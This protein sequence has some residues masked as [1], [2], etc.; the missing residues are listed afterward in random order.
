MLFLR[1]TS[2]NPDTLNYS[3]RG[4][5]HHSRRTRTKKPQRLQCGWCWVRPGHVVALAR[6]SPPHQPPARNLPVL[7][8][9]DRAGFKIIA[10][11]MRQCMVADDTGTRRIDE[12][13]LERLFLTL[14]WPSADHHTDWRSSH[15]GL[16][17]QHHPQPA[18]RRGAHAN[19]VALTEQGFGVLS[20]TA[21]LRGPGGGGWP[22]SIQRL[23]HVVAPDQAVE[24]GHLAAVA[25]PD[26]GGD[27]LHVEVAGRIGARVDVDAV[28]EEL[29]RPAVGDLL[30]P[31]H[32]CSARGER[33]L[34]EVQ[35]HKTRHV[36]RGVV[37]AVEGGGQGLLA[38][39]EASGQLVLGG[40][41]IGRRERRC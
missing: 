32:Q 35:R 4:T 39:E 25:K 37:E 41:V 38:E 31:G 23:L 12:G 30:Q 19:P 10:T 34:P 1:S 3:S 24:A 27:G 21:S 9:A 36:E 20:A 40:G 22:V 8:D 13:E 17:T 18:L 6:A 33:G 11:R 14:A 26:Q 28:A 5:M 2:Q 16:P 29:P 7:P 15:D